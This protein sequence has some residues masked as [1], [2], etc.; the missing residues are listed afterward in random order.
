[1]NYANRKSGTN[2]G[3][4]EWGEQHGKTRLDFMPGVRQQNTPANKER[5]RIDTLSSVLSQAQERVI[6][7][8][9][10]ANGIGYQRARRFDAEPI[11]QERVLMLS[12]FSCLYRF[13]ICPAAEKKKP[14]WADHSLCSKAGHGG[15]WEAS[16]CLF[17]F[18]IR[19]IYQK[20]LVRFMGTVWQRMRNTAAPK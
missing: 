2:I 13:I 1:M 15:I 4:A 20:K 11:T 7:Q 10:T 5:Y 17:S 14:P 18:S 19:L 9:K 3:A 12:A 8:C 6:D 16:P